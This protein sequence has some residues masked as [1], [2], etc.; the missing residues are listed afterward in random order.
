[1]AEPPAKR[2]KRTDSSAMWER[3]TT[4]SVKS[5]TIEIGT[6]AAMSEDTDPDPKR[7][8]EKGVDRKT[9]QR[10]PVESGATQ[11]KEE[12]GDIKTE[13]EMGRGIRGIGK[14]V[15][16]GRSTG[17]GEVDEPASRRSRSPR[18]DH[19]STRTRTHTPPRASKPIPPRSPR[20]NTPTERAPPTGPRSTKAAPSKAP[21]PARTSSPKPNGHANGTIASAEPSIKKEKDAMEVDEDSD[22]EMAEMRRAMGFTG[23]KSTKNTKVKGNNVSGLRKEKKT[24]YRQY[25]NRV[26]GFNRP[27]SPSR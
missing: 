26:G 16:V 23:F 7:G 21:P 4:T 6:T 3:N 20:S 19:T 24:E 18:H 10:N 1:M 25:M 12:G 5:E 22:P 15:G 14:G 2:A 9:G 17:R 27:L 8:G 11:E 13:S